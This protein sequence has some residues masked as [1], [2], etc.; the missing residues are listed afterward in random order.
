[1]LKD[2]PIPVFTVG[3]VDGR[4]WEMFSGIRSVA[5]D[6]SDNLY[7]LDGQN[8]RVVVFDANGKFV[9]QFGRKGG[10][11]GELQAP[12]AMDIASDGSVVVSDLG[13]RAFIV[14]RPDGE[15]VRN[16]PFDEELGFPMNM[17]A[18]ARAGIIVRATA[19]VRPDQPVVDH[20]SPIYRQPLAGTAAA[21]P[22]YRVPTPAPRVMQSTGTGPAR[23]VSMSMDPVF[24]PRPT[25]GALPAGV[26]LHHESAYAVRI[27]DAA[28]RHVRTL[29]RDFKPRKV[30][31][32][33]QEEWLEQR[34]NDAA[35]GTGPTVV[36][37]RATPAGRSA[38]VGTGGQAPSGMAMSLDNV[39]FAEFMSVVTSIRTDPQSRI[40][41]QRRGADG[42]A[43]GPID[44]MMPDG[45]YIGTLPPQ[46]LP[47]AVSASSLAAWVVTDAELGVERVV[48]RRLPASWQ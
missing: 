10:G 35:N 14:F 24:G 48:V 28:G 36:M 17:A 20:F 39:E 45:R 7:L 34:R 25:F 26:A 31:K 12:L 46:E 8:R 11:P 33:D 9:R 2:R 47:G 4:D 44:L 38:S 19:R 3:T 18:D 5:F 1:M 40:W 43:A 21:Q 16:I 27:L 13:N 15:Y 42:K 29:T 37:M 23:R 22:L 41:V 30:T 32:K 6:R